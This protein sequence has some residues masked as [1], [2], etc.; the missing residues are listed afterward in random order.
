[1]KW[2][3]GVDGG[4]SKTHALICDEAG[5]VVGFAQADGSNHETIG[6]AGAERVLEGIARDALVQSGLAAPIDHAFWCLAGADVKTDFAQL[7][8]IAAR[9]A[10]AKQNVV[11]ND[12]AA[13]MGAGFSRGW[14][15]A[16]I[17]GAGFSSGG[18]AP[19]GRRLQFP[20]LGAAT[21]DWGGSGDIGLEVLRLAHRSYDG[22][23]TPSVLSVQVPHALGLTSLE[24]I[25]QQLR[26]GAIDW[27]AVRE[28][29]PPLVFAA[30]TEGDQVAID[31]TLRIGVEVGLTAA[32]IIR[33]LEMASLD[34]ELVLSGSVLRAAPSLL[35]DAIDSAV[36]KEAASVRIIR[37]ELPPVVGAV[38]LS[39]RAM[40]I[41]VDERIRSNI[42]TTLTPEMIG[43]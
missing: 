11:N 38:F 13:A 29:L 10:A 34:V 1:M 5:H 14:G 22:R 32:A 36:R 8:A 4:N 9:I 16:V 18:I 23:E 20:S 26:A 37:S 31:L 12:I 21:G 41:E 3:L 27:D 6:F 30:A 39:L 43:P 17:C 19:D 2:V 33:R 35:V 15:V 7:S 28:K 40:G 24:E 42:R 25:P